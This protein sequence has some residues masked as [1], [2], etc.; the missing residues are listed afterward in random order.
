[1]AQM[2]ITETQS[3]WYENIYVKKYIYM[4]FAENHNIVVNFK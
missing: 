1:M 4:S 3:M 2:I